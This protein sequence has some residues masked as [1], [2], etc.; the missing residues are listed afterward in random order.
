MKSTLFLSAAL[1]ALL[2]PALP[3]RASNPLL[4]WSQS[5]GT[6]L[7]QEGSGVATDGQGNIFLT[8]RSGGLTSFGGPL[9]TGNGGYDVFIARYNSSGLHLGS[10]AYGGTGADEGL[11]IAADSFGNFIVTGYFFGTDDFGGGNL[12]SQGQDIFIAKYGPN[13]NHLW[14]HGFG[15]TGS[16]WGYS[17]AV[18][19][20]DNVFFSGAFEGTVDFGGGNLVSNGN[21]DI[22]LAKFNSNGVHQWSQS[23]G[24]I[25]ID[26]G[27]GV[28]VDPSGNV[29]MVGGFL[30]T[31]DFGGGDLTNSGSTDVILAKYDTNGGHI[32]S[33]RFGG[34]GQESG[35]GVTVDGAGNVIITGRFRST[36]DFGGG[37]LVSAGGDDIFLASYDAN[38]THKWS[39]RFGGTEDDAGYSVAV[40]SW[41]KVI[42]TGEFRGTADFGGGPRTSEGFI[43][44]YLA[45]YDSTGAYI[46]SQRFGDTGD[47]SGRSVA[48][49]DSD[50]FVL[51]GWFNDTVNLGEGDLTSAGIED[52][53]L[54]KFSGVLVDPLITAVTDIGNDQGGQVLI[55]FDRSAYDD[56]T[57]P[58]AISEYE[59][60]R[61]ID[62][63]P[64][65]GTSP[66]GVS[67]G[68]AAFDLGWTFVGSVPAHG[69]AGYSIVA[70]TIGDSTVTAGQ[71]YS[72]FFIRAA[73]ENPFLYCDSP[74]DSGYS[75]DNLAPSV[76]MN[77]VYTGGVLTWAATPPADF[78]YFTVY[79]SNSATWTS[80]TTVVEYTVSPIADVSASPYPFYFVTATD[81]SGNESPPAELSS[82]T[83]VQGR[84]E[85]IVLSV[86]N[87][88]NPLKPSTMIRYTVPRV[89]RVTVAVYDPRGSRV[90]TLVAEEHHEPGVFETAWNR[91]SDNGVRLPA[92]VYLLRIEQEG[93]QRGRKMILLD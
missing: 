88:P 73:T 72:V 2:F 24:D 13:G 68:L 34:N 10:W 11:A 53:F 83:S 37:G 86:T 56:P 65:L 52:V 16:D 81:F 91:R 26:R 60:Y 82:S 1:S 14:S 21:N 78:D 12:V 70:P 93:T 3:A 47:D 4:L 67:P 40:N 85:G 87:F 55:E 15:N 19:A 44:I 8:G 49:D 58:Y 46:S 92:G 77:L 9:V 25:S 63:P 23:F 6:N 36:V 32:W 64:A 30:G 42:T 79:G 33:Q 48:V 50:N 54:A 22:I 61:R 71:Y 28:A 45:E 38:G 62:P 31:V 90:S 80:S 57:A 41:G 59:A 18:D 29:I 5:F 66:P 35:R 89:G 17:V 69:Q 20:S 27:Y 75:I 51:G 76:P 39:R 84:P 43:D 7:V 74:P